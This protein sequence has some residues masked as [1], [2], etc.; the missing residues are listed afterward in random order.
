[1]PALG[2][3]LNSA[4]YLPLTIWL[5]RVPYTGHTHD[6]GE[7]RRLGM[8]WRDALATLGAVKHNHTVVAMIALAATT[9]FMVGSGLQAQ[10]PG[11]AH[12]LGTD[13]AGVAYSALLMANAVGAVV[14]GVLLESLGLLQS[15]ARTAI[16]LAML[17]S[18]TLAG[19]AAAPNY[20]VA[21]ALL[22]LMGLFNLASSSR[23]R[24]TS[25]G[26]WWGCSTWPSRGCAWAAAS[27]WASW[28]A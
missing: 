12:D 26:A 1:G 4:M 13:E 3:L 24:P 16:V 21:I 14:G 9:S 22:F 28:A 8:G 11:F 17:W 25:A 27:R 10:M 18:L 7:P 15:R 20:A 19:F 6:T 5:S 23:R 2:M